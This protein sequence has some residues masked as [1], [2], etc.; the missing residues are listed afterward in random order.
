[1]IKGGLGGKRYLGGEVGIKRQ[2]LSFP[3]LDIVVLFKLSG[4]PEG[5]HASMQGAIFTHQ[6]TIV[7]ISPF[8]GNLFPTT[9]ALD[10]FLIN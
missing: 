6:F 1:M 5:K 3:V 7:G 10:I 2:T 4:M 9:T 8:S